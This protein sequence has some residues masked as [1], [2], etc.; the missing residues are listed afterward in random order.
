MASK[1]REFMKKNQGKNGFESVMTNRVL[2]TK[3]SVQ[4]ID[5]LLCGVIHRHI[6]LIFVKK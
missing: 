3:K 2:F 6:D 4:I 5:H 1:V